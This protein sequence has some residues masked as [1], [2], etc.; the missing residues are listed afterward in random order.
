MNYPPKIA[1]CLLKK[2]QH[3]ARSAIRKYLGVA[4]QPLPCPVPASD[5]KSRLTR[6]E[7]QIAQLLVEGMVGVRKYWIRG[8]R[9]N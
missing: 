6:R 1:A 5:K 3:L 9:S 2:V 7:Q 8:K 4:R